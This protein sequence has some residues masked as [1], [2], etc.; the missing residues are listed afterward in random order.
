MDKLSNRLTI[1]THNGKQ[2]VFVD[3]KRLK[4]K[5]MIELVN[6]H[7]ELTLQTKLP[8][9]ADFHKT[10]VTPGYMIHARRFAESTKQIIDKGA[11]LGV[12]RI[13]SFILKGTVYMIGVNYKAFDNREQAI[14]FL[15]E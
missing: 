2:I 1:E 9:L 12:D 3:Y 8:F 15:I 6:K 10:F 5:D 4:E 14:N 11:L 7:L 13:K